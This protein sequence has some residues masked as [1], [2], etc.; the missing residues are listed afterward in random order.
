[1]TN[2]YF[3]LEQRKKVSRHWLQDPNQSNVDN[4]NN[5]RCEAGRHFRNKKKEYLKA[6]IDEL[7]TNGK[8]NNIRALCRGISD[9]K[10]CYQPRTLVVKDKNGDLV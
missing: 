2:V 6:K 3:F 4:V 8:F 9:F 10:K 7:E 1:M 5:V